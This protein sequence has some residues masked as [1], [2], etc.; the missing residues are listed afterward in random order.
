[1]A[2]SGEK[3]A[4]GTRRM[5]AA[6]S[7]DE[8]RMPR[9]ESRLPLILDLAERAL[10]VFLY[11]LLVE[12]LWPSLASAPFN[13]LL[14]VAETIVVGFVVARRLTSIVTKKPI[15]WLLALGGTL[16]PLFFH[17][18]GA[19]FAPAAA[20]GGLM[21]LGICVQ[22]SAKFFLRR[23]FGIAAANRG[24]KIGGP[25]RLVRHPMYLGYAI[26][27]IGFLSVNALPLNFALALFAL[28]MQV[29]R[30]LVEERLLGADPAYR[31]YAR[32]VRFRVVP[33]LF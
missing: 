4:S 2:V 7:R 9:A 26:T 21:A 6:A 14:I 24:V 30:I 1:V 18:G 3:V 31:D 20:A 11:G 23:S 8:D 33:G 27:W 25:Y 32:K 28:A 13:A 19:R 5:T 12:R 29:C 17:A 22:V 10:L 16:P 15:D